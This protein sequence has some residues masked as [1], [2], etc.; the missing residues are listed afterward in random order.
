MLYIYMHW[1]CMVN[2]VILQIVQT[3]DCVLLCIVD[4]ETIE[5]STKHLCV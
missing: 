2:L 5:T 4:Q 3:N 1:L